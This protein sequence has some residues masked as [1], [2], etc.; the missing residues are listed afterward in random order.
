MIESIFL[1]LIGMA[2]ILFI[3]GIE[4]TSTIYSGT[5]LILWVL[6]MAQSLYIHVPGDTAYQEYGLNAF[7]LVFIFINIIWIIIMYMTKQS[8]KRYR[9]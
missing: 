6:I 2:F 7:A 4:L 5:S 3:L 1:I 9:L 8:K